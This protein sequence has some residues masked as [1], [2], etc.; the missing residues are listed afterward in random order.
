[1]TQIELITGSPASFVFPSVEKVLFFL[2]AKWWWC[3]P[4]TAWGCSNSLPYILSPSAAKGKKERERKGSAAGPRWPRRDRNPVRISL[5]ERW[6]LGETGIHA[7][8]ELRCRHGNK[9]ERKEKASSIESLVLLLTFL[10]MK[11]YIS[12]FLSLC[13]LFFSFLCSLIEESFTCEWNTFDQNDFRLKGELKKLR[14][15]SSFCF[16]SSS[17]A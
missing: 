13:L 12:F 11:Q 1:M 16:F 7:D 4:I 8:I 17:K 6:S 3:K 9:R 5:T 14:H 15:R 10:C 2:V